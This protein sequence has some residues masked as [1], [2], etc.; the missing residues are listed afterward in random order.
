MTFIKNN[1]GETLHIIYRRSDLE[2]LDFRE[3]I[4]S[5]SEFLQL[6]AIK[7]PSKHKFRGHKHLKLVRETD[8]TQECWIV[9]KGR[10]KTFHYDEDDNFLE[11]NILEE[12]DSTITFRG[13]H[14]YQALDE[15]ALVYEIKTGPYMGQAKDKVFINGEA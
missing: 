1:K 4:S 13:G 3:D 12:G 11:E 6:A 7:I 2:S 5:D 15:G 9:I 8:I 14:N 10:V